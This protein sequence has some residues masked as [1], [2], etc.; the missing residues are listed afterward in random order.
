MG[1]V[2]LVRHGQASF[3]ADD[4]DALSD[5]G[6]EQSRLL[7]A[8]LAARGI[9]PDTVLTGT[10]RRHRE[11]AETCAEAAGWSVEPVVDEGWD[12]FDFLAI[13]K[14]H[15]HAAPR[16]E[17]TRAEFQ[18]WFEEATGQWVAGAERGYAETF[19]GFTARVDE[20]LARTTSYDGTVV[21]FTSGGPIAWAA[22]S[23]L[24]D[25]GAPEVWR[26]L[27]R[28]A[29]NAAV[30][31]LITSRRGVNLLSYNEQAHLDGVPGAVSYR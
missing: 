6:F 9:T 24:V 12:E 26:R 31:R 29:V 2:L 8:A 15:E 13:L 28:V 11:T 19:A 17:P 20:A 4:Y 21:V 5:L 10:M 30:T 22:A 7:G 16:H 14:A 25:G 3:G 27:N 23:L 1:Q 18:R